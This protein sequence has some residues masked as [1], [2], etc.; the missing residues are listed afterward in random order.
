MKPD[1]KQVLASRTESMASSAIREILKVANRP[2]MITLAGGIPAPETFPMDILEQV[3]SRVISKWGASAFQYD[4]TEGF[5]PLREAAVSYLQ[6]YSV[7]ASSEEILVSSGSQGLLDSIGKILISP[8]NTVAV[9]S[10]T[11][12]GA[13]QAFNPYGPRY[14]EIKSD[15]N[16]AVPESLEEVLVKDRPKFVYLVP[17][18]QNPSGRTIPLQRRKTIAEIIIRHNALLIEDD[19]YAALRYRGDVVP[20]IKSMAPSHVLYATTFSK[21]FA[22]GLRV[23]LA[24]PPTGELGSW[25]VK[26]KQGTDLHTSTLSQAMAAVYLEEGYLEERLP[27]IC[28]FYAPRLDAM[29]DAMDE[30]FPSEWNWSRPEGGMFLWA[31]GPVG[32][33]I[34]KLYEKALSR[35]V[36]FVPGR[37]FFAHPDSGSRTMRLNFTNANPDMLQKA[38]RT[39]ASLIAN[40]I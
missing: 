29:L 10:P 20:S 5:I 39:L 25:L 15:E 12:L 9:E 17:T 24:V 18:F 13:L 2:G 23:G 27:L 31:E 33:D 34:L 8:G 22:P 16:G 21:V 4:L 14:V 6:R 11:Y 32:T 36:A 30:S 19:P 28:D 35:N 26:A 40:Q 37:Y 7:E 3:F 38:I 1:F